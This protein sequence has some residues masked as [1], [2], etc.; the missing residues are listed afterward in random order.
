MKKYLG[1]L[2]ALALLAASLFGLWQVI[3]GEFEKVS[4]GRQEQNLP[5]ATSTEPS[6]AA[7]APYT[8]ESVPAPAKPPKS[9]EVRLTAYLTSY[10]WW[11]NTPAGSR[12]I[13]FRRSDG[14]PTLHD[15]AGGTGTYADPIT[16]AVGHVIENGID[17][18][19][20]APGTRFYIPNVR[21][22]F[23]TED[24]CGDGDTPQNKPC[25]SLRAAD[26]GADVWLD[27][28]I[29]GEG[30]SREEA[31]A[32]ARALTANHLVIRDPLPDYAVSAGPIIS[33][34]TCRKQYGDTLV[35]N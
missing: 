11:D 17:T 15:I 26:P 28:W 32:C 1:P 21:A 19:D 34:S 33:G 5:A 23:I 31:D 6:V 22:Y 20:F 18:P 14:F 7:E 16:V 27:M 24:T 10:T 13:A 9:K 30:V 35:K 3:T 12:I 2:V 25:H 8:E 4:I 29:D